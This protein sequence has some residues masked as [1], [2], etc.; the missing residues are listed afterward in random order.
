MGIR[1]SSHLL[2][3]LTAGLLAG[4]YALPSQAEEPV[5]PERLKNAASEPQNWLMPNKEY[6]SNRHS[7]LDEINKENVGDLKVAYTVAIGGLEGG[8]N[9]PQGGHQSTPVVNDGMMYV[10][11]AWGTVYKIDVSDGKKGRIVWVM[12]PGIDKADVWI[13]SNRGVS[14]YNDK[15]ISVTADGKVNWTDAETG[16]LLNSVQ[17]DDPANGYSLTAPPLVIG[18]TLIVPGSGGDR[19]ARDHVTAL[20]AET[21]EQLWRTYTIPGPGE[22]GHETWGGDNNAWMHGGGAVWQV[23]SYDPETDLTFWGTGQ[24]VP[25]FDPEYRPGDNLYTNS[26]LAL[27]PESG[28]IKWWFQYTPGDYMDYD[29]AGTRLLVDAEWDGEQRKLMGYFGRNGFYYTH[30]RTNGQFLGATQYADK[31]NWTDGI[32][33]KTGLPVEYDPDKE[34]QIYKI[35]AP[36][37]RDQGPVVGCPHIQGGVNYF[38]TAF[39]PET[40][41]SYGAG[42]EGCSEVTAD[43]ERSDGTIAWNGGK[44][45]DQG[46]LLGS[47]TAMDIKT[48][49][50]KAQKMF[51]YP[52]YAGV[53]S[54]AGGLVFVPTLDGTLHALDAETLEEAWSFNVGSGIS[55]PP[56][57]FGVDGKQYIAVLA[58]INRIPK[59]RI[60][61]TPE[62]QDMQNTSMLFVFAL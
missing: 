54:T 16:E 3:A 59:G 52:S 37:R 43:P 25:M 21:G 28:E 4:V 17:V 29:E 36:S 7:Q 62:L 34:L 5:T 14:L 23:G 27:D 41:L 20:N 2:A 51:D 57:S 26:T 32:D 55:S 46:R 19:G 58:G 42:I 60:A 22:P 1:K 15:V 33:P 12:D 45:V 30:D 18:D 53:L 39:N 40:G 8:G 6:N 13:A 38:P 35:G 48:G 10:V 44:H 61:N 24:P 50:K 56:M 11:D 9:N 31:V 49:E 47:I